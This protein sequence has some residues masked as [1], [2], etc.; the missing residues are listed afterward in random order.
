[1]ALARDR[2]DREIGEGIITPA[3][4]SLIIKHAESRTRQEFKG[5]RRGNRDAFRYLLTGMLR[6][7]TCGGACAVNGTSYQCQASRP[8][9]AMQGAPPTAAV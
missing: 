2:R 7:G 5:R 1:M 9:T 6:C 8:G 3:E 4:R